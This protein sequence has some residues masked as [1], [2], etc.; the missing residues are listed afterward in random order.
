[1][2][3]IIQKLVK[4]DIR[5]ITMVLGY[6]AEEIQEHLNTE[7]PDLNFNYVIN[8]RYDSTNNLVSLGMGLSA[9]KDRSDVL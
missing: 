6:Q 1:M 3:G 8:E 2:A 9:I 7:F 4:N 5:D